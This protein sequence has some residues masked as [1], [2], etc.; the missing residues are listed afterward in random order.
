MEK[1]PRGQ[2]FIELAIV[3]PLLILLGLGVFEFSRMLY[4]KNAIINMSRE[5]ANLASRTLTAPQDIMNALASTAPQSLNMSANGMIYITQVGGRAD[6]NIEVITQYKWLLAG[7]SPIPASKV[8][9]ACTPY[10]SGAC[11]PNPRPLASLTA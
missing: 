2:S 4:A 3:L 9:G 10:V 1:A 8:L 5:G 6:G 11:T 7:V